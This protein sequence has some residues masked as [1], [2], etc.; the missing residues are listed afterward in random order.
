MSELIDPT[1][2]DTPSIFLLN[3]MTAEAKRG[4]LLEHFKITLNTNEPTKVEVELKING[5]EVDFSKSIT[6][7]W[8]RLQASYDEDVLEKA[9]ELVSQTRLQ[10]LND[11]L[12]D[13]EYKIQAELE[14][15]FN[16]RD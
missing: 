7:M 10:K 13:A 4:D 2:N 6:E 9:K 16:K 1:L 15:L 12:Q 14:E 5:V 3:M 11:L 8:N